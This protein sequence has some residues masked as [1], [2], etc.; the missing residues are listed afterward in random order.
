MATKIT[1]FT[2]QEKKC[3]KCNCSN[4]IVWSYYGRELHSCKMQG[5]SDT[6][7][8]KAQKDCPLNK[9]GRGKKGP[10]L[11]LTD[12][13][14][15]VL[16]KLARRSKMDAWFAIDDAGKVVDLED[17]STGERQAIKTFVEGFTEYDIEGLS[18]SETLTLLTLLGKLI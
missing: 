18:A 3:I 1:P 15:A 2:D 14:I 8:R 7:E 16:E 17:C 4:F 6:V 9:H 13:E 11:N 12:S 10:G 5:E